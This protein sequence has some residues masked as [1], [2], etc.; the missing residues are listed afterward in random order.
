VIPADLQTAL[1]TR[2]GDV[3]LELVGD[4]LDSAA[5]LVRGAAEALARGEEGERGLRVAE[6]PFR[7]LALREMRRF[8][9]EDRGGGGGGE[10]DD[11]AADSRAESTIGRRP[12]TGNGLSKQVMWCS[13]CSRQ[14]C[15][16]AVTMRT[17][18]AIAGGNNR[19]IVLHFFLLLWNF[20]V[21]HISSV[22]FIETTCFQSEQ[23]LSKRRSSKV[24][25]CKHN[26]FKP[27]TIEKNFPHNFKL[28]HSYIKMIK[29]QSVWSLYF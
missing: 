21:L 7:Q 17:C 25:M 27:S 10:H 28:A 9:E 11:W 2:G 22:D 5:G 15:T 8:R 26:M 3:D 13:S 16:I 14:R 20:S 18:K 12:C 6:G 24:E 23:S 19:N 29:V 1:L 4:R